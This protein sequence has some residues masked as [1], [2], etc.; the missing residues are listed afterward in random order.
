LYFCCFFRNRQ[1]CAVGFFR[2]FSFSLYNIFRFLSLVSVVDGALR[3]FVVFA[4]AY[5]P[6]HMYVSKVG[7]AFR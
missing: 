2:F 5:V 4:C 3:N 7:S 1:V 6:L